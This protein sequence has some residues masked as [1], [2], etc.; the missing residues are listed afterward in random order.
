MMMMMTM[1]IEIFINIQ[2]YDKIKK[3][4]YLLKKILKKFNF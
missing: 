4:Q 2:I 3:K 1:K